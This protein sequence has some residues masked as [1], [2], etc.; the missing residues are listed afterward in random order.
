MP[1]KI[2]QKV[3]FYSLSFLFILWTYLACGQTKNWHVA[4]AKGRFKFSVWA[5]TIT[6]LDSNL[7]QVVLSKEAILFRNNPFQAFFRAKNVEFAPLQGD[8]L[9]KI[10][11]GNKSIV[12]SKNLQKEVFRQVSQFESWHNKPLI[13]MEGKWVFRPG[14]AEEQDADSF[15]V[16]KSNLILF[17]PGGLVE[18]DS[19]FRTRFFPVLE[20]EKNT[21]P[22][23]TYFL[24]DS[25]WIPFNREKMPFRLSKKGFWW[26]DSLYVDSTQ[27]SW[28]WGSKR[29]GSWKWPDSVSALSSSFMIGKRLNQFYIFSHLSRQTKISKPLE[30]KFLADTLI[31]F[32]DRKNQWLLGSSCIKW[33]INKSIDQVYSYSESLILAKAGKRFGFIDEFGFI[34][35]ACRYDSLFP[36]SE[37]RAAARLGNYWGFLDKDEKLAVQPNFEEVKSFQNQIAPVKKN[38][39][40]GLINPNG[41]FILPLEYDSVFILP[42]GNWAFQKNNWIGWT[43]S[44]GK[45]IAQPRFLSII[46]PSSGFVLVSRDQ[47][48]GLLDQNGKVLIELNWK[49]IIIQPRFQTLIFY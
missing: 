5:D 46:E 12:S 22:S 28:K 16:G 41:G 33:K 34:R 15:R 47:K 44:K 2:C 40:W 31:F 30:V 38:G 3:N 7:F 1:E 11:D 25:S 27:G 14:E 8:W 23:C 45:I 49:K 6:A 26:N 24:T 37:G 35:I 42:S 43:D 48:E 20:K 21:N 39:K 4:D 10:Q 32:K 19:I 36:F 18:V 17:V 13:Q 9:W 29:K